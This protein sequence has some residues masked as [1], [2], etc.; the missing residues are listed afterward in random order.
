L[1]NASL[2]RPEAPCCMKGVDGY[3]PLIIFVQKLYTRTT[4]SICIAHS[5]QLYNQKIAKLLQH[6][7]SV[8]KQLQQA[9][10]NFIWDYKLQKGM[11]A[12]SADRRLQV[13]SAQA[14]DPALCT[15]HIFVLHLLQLCRCFVSSLN[16]PVL[17]RPCFSLIYVT[18]CCGS[19][20][21]L[22]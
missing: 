3:A 5:S 22:F 4:L 7:L 18:T 12:R 21:S 20:F 17:D 11:L 2:S 13:P 8:H 9:M 1:F 15:F 10:C 6:D 19:R 14:L 16:V